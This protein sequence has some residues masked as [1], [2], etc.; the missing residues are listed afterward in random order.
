MLSSDISG[1][2]RT[3]LVSQ[4][5]SQGIVFSS[6]IFGHRL[7]NLLRDSE[8]DHWHISLL[9]LSCFSSLPSGDVGTCHLLVNERKHNSLFCISGKREGAITVACRSYRGGPREEE[10]LVQGLEEDPGC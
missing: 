6:L 1:L 9:F 4:N 2:I 10:R 3:G 7:Q 5:I 8:P